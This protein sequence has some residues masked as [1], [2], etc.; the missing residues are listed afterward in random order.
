MAVE[1]TTAAL[2]ALSGTLKSPNLVLKIEDVDT[3]YGA[4]LIEQVARIGDDLIIGEADVNPKAFYVGGN[5][6]NGDQ[7]DIITLDGT[8]TSIKQTL[9]PSK[10]QGSNVSTLSIALIDNGE[11][12]EL[13]TPGSVVPDILQSKC[14]V[15]LGF[16]GTSWPEDYSVVFRGFITDISCDAGKVTFQINGTDERQRTSIFTKATVKLTT[17]MTTS[18]TSMT[19]DTV[20]GVLQPI[21]GPNGQMDPT[22]SAYFKID[23]EIIGW[24]NITASSNGFVTT[25]TVNG[26]ARAQYGT[27][28]AT[29]DLGASADTFYRLTG[30]AI[31]LALKLMASGNV[32][33]D[34]TTLQTTI[35]PFNTLPVTSMNV[36]GLEYVQN[37]L[38]FRGVINDNDLGVSIGDFVTISGSPNLFNNFSSVVTAVTQGEAGCFVSVALPLLDE[39]VSVASAAFISQFAT[40]PDGCQMAPDEID[41]TQFLRI[42]QLYLN[43]ITLDFYLKD[44]IDQAK[45]FIEQEIYLPLSAYSIPRKAKTSVGYFS[46]PIPGNNIVSFDNTNIKSPQSIAVKRSTNSNFY[47]EIVYKYDEDPV[48]DQY[49]SGYIGVSQT[50]KSRIP[51]SPNKTLVI[52]SKGLRSL[53]GAKLTVLDQVTRRFNRYQYGAESFT[54]SSLLSDG[55]TVEVGDITLFDGTNLMLP[56]IKTGQK[57]ISPRLLEIQNREIQLKTGDLKFT[58]LDTN[59]NGAGRHALIS[60]AS[61]ITSATSASAFTLFTDQPPE[62]LIAAIPEYYKWRQLVGSAVQVRNADFSIRGYTTLIRADSNNVQVAPALPFVPQTDMIMEFAPY[63]NA[64]STKT[65][66]LVYGYMTDQPFADGSDPYTMI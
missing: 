51:N 60:P 35:H 4:G 18:S 16:Q 40:L 38:F 37:S 66:H 45:D 12:T 10:G 59:F 47:N 33:T 39:Q 41:V 42:K 27:A 58:A 53:N 31:D 48:E 63:S 8:S 50:S 57:G 15:Y 64:A 2:A 62:T 46:G 65:Q 14:L 20:A 17:A 54:F 32:S 11:V 43:G 28:A 13:I 49:N 22:F 36:G 30:N 21:T 34:T 61:Y 55:Y 56:D 24:T 23:D 9:D 44:T 25:Y 5:G 26:L 3:L 7:R 6:P 29:H 1:L 52:E 19:I